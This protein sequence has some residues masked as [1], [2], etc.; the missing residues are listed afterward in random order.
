MRPKTSAFVGVSLDGFLAKLDDTLDWLKPFEASDHGY[1]AFIG[2]VDTLLIGRRTYDFVQK[3]VA[4][5]LGWPYAGKRC[6]VL[7]HRP[8]SGANGER[9][10]AGSP[11]EALAM[12]EREGAKHVYVDG[13]EAI[14]SF[15]AARLLDR[16]T[17]SIVPRLIGAGRPLF[18]GVEA[19][20]ELVFEGA[21]TYSDG[22]VQLRYRLE[23]A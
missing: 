15:I 20:A 12:L 1:G 4:D 6:V 10:F 3:M 21:E 16:L 11:A 7:T 19:G 9:A 17:V 13:G 2:T 14:R 5:G 18:G 23:H 8:V 22:L